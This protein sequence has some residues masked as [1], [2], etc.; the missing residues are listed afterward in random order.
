MALNDTINI[1]VK[2]TGTESVYLTQCT[3]D[4]ILREIQIRHHDSI[5]VNYF[6]V[7]CQDLYTPGG[8]A[9]KPNHEYRE[10]LLA[11]LLQKGVYRYLLHWSKKKNRC[12]EIDSLCSFRVEQRFQNRFSIT[13]IGTV[14]WKHKET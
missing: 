5:W 10:S 14:A 12:D 3:S 2:N 6:A 11:G 8:Y 13:K 9:L 7:I 4:K 1:T